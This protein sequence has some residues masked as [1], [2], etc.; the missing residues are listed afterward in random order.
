ML[1]DIIFQQNC[2]AHKKKPKYQ[3]FVYYRYFNSLYL[4]SYLQGIPQK[5]QKTVKF[6]WQPVQIAT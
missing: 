6:I 4:M 5:L 3:Q 2:F 1:L